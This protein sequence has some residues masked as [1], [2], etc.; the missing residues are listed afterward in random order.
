MLSRL[1]LRNTRTKAMPLAAPSAIQSRSFGL[2]IDQLKKIGVVGAGQLGSGIGLLTASKLPN[3]K[4]E[5]V[6]VDAG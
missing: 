3:V 5:F 6:D 1:A 2:Q 4:V